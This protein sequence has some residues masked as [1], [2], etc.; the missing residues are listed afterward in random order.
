MEGAQVV[1]ASVLAYSALP[2]VYALRR[3]NV[4]F[5][6]LYTHLAGLLAFGWILGGLYEMR[7]GDV[8]LL[9]GELSYGGFVLTAV[10]TVVVGRDL[11]VVRNI[12]GLTLAVCSLGLVFFTVARLALAV[13]GTADPHG[14]VPALLD[15][16]PVVAVVFALFVVG[17]LLLLLNLLEVAKRRLPGAVMPLVYPAVFVAVL[18]V[19]GVLGALLSGGSPGEELVAKL[20]VTALYLPALLAFVAL[21]R[22][23]VTAFESRPLHLRH[24]LSTSH[25][26]LLDELESKA[27]ELAEQRS[28]TLA[29]DA[30]VGRVNAT[31]ERILDSATNTILIALD[32]DLRITHF[33][34]GAQALL[35]WTPREV[36]GQGLEV[37]LP[38]EEIARHAS[39]LGTGP[40]LVQVLQVQMAVDARRDWLMLS[41]HD[42][43]PTVSM[44]VSQVLVDGHVVG[45]ILAGEDVTSRLRVETA[46]MTALSRE[47]DAL[48][49]LQEADRVKHE[50]VSTVSHELRTPIASITGYTEM[51]HDGAYGE[52]SKDQ[53]AALDRVL[54]NTSRLER[55]VDDLLVLE[56]VEQA[57]LPL[58]REPVDLCDVIRG[59]KSIVGEMVRGRDLK[60]SVSL[61]ASPVTLDGDRAA[62]ERLVINLLSNAVKFTPGRGTVALRVTSHS[63]QAW[64]TVTDT[65]MGVAESDQPHVFA[66]FYRTN[67][68]N[69]LAIPGSGL[70]LSIVQAVVAGH[71][72]E[73]SLASTPGEGTTVTVSLPME[74]VLGSVNGSAADPDAVVRAG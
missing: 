32:P 44:G 51:L 68:A 61:P 62:L 33:N 28:L 29:S 25:Q 23:S 47:H 11:Q 48:V 70:G 38:A 74:P 7:L 12:I 31:V 19:H 4:Q 60:F 59:T 8:A 27:H 43:C 14:V 49:R 52:L 22:R 50:L 41:R 18:L 45:H 56:R 54:R 1:V 35:G 65:G 66:R 17:E 73:V 15:R 42:T 20:V 30:S 10:V 24:L 21:Y 16:S 13:P 69:E 9:P 34:S 53:V 57:P 46:M 63:G 72:G 55:L 58:V 5:L 26:P 2:L 64:L 71:G 6:L 67:Q 3:W 37:L 36:C 39:A 40:E